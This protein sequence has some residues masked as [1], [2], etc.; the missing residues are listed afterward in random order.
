MNLRAYFS[1]QREVTD[2]LSTLSLETA[3]RVHDLDTHPSTNFGMQVG[4]EIPGQQQH[5]SSHLR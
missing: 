5:V 4:D 1:P 2:L 3:V